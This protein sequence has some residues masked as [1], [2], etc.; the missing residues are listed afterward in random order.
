MVGGILLVAVTTFA[1]APLKLCSLCEG[2]RQ[3][4]SVDM[5]A[6]PITPG[7]YDL[8]KSDPEDYSWVDCSR[9]HGRGR[10]GVLRAWLG[11]R[12]NT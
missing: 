7:E 4:V 9:C 5:G 6:E 1:L 3:M 10:T 11:R 2:E 8:T 12:G